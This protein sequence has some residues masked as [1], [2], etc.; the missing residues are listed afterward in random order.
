LLEIH[1][2]SGHVLFSHLLLRTVTV[3]CALLQFVVQ[4][5]LFLHLVG[6]G[7]SRERLLIFG[8]A[9]VIVSILVIGSLWIMFTL[10][11]RMM[12]SQM[13]MEQYMQSQSGL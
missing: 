3:V 10:N 4:A 13:Q 8:A 11:G 2:Q 6:K 9:V 7:A 5:T 1:I 12:P